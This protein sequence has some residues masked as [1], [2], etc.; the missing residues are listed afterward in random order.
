MDFYRK[1][2]DNTVYYRFFCH[3]SGTCRYYSLCRSPEFITYR[4]YNCYIQT[5]YIIARNSGTY[6][7]SS[8]NTPGDRFTKANCQ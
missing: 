5:I 4:F 7:N 1:Y 8:D 6:C 2:H 3:I